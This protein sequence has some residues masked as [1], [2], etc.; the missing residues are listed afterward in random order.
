[1]SNYYFNL[2]TFLLI[3]FNSGAVAQTA[4]ELILPEELYGTVQLN[5]SFTAD[6][7]KKIS[8][9]EKLAVFV[10]ND[11]DKYTSNAIQGHYT[12]DEK[13]L[14]FKP[15][16]PYEKGMTYV[17]RTMND[18]SDGTYSYRPFQIGKKGI[19][20]EAKV[21][22][23]YPT[24][25][26]LPENLLRFYIYF[27]TPMKKGQALE[28]IKLIDE[29]GNIDNHVFMEFKQELWSADGKRL[30]LLFDPG[31]IK[32]GVSTNLLRGP[33]LKEGKQYKL[34]ISGIWQDV[35]GQ[36]LTINSIK[37]FVADNGYHQDIKTNDWFIDVPE[38]N[39]ND[40]LTL[41]F[42]RIIDH[43][44][45]QSM[46]KLENSEKNYIAGHWEILEN[47]QLIRF[48]PEKKWMKGNYQILIDSR[49]EDVAGNNLQNLLD[50]IKTDD[51][52]N[53]ETHHYIKFKI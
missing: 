34:S 24:A 2:I 49:L 17:V 25:D 15:Y 22:S 36:Q 18:K 3:A 42:D 19:V 46:I 53:S 31:R 5:T 23:I 39:T 35:Y 45:I 40:P 52:S 28:H 37:E 47:E 14:V 27:N 30:T 13:Y 32:R 4:P 44:L 9:Y 26:Q 41:K 33:A 6:Q 12:Y 38:A 51:E 48:I 21:I 16:F 43:A 50:H 10:K 7:N 1:M 8:D 20:E 29:E 11:A